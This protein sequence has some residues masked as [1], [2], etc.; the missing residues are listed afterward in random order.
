MRFKDD[1]P[2]YLQIYEYLCRQIITGKLMSNQKIP[3]IRSLA[4]LFTV[5]INTIQKALRQMNDSGLLVTKRGE[6][7][8]VTKD[9][10]FVAKIKKDLIIAEQNKFVQNMRNL[11]VSSKQIILIVANHLK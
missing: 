11:G 4:T 5:N 9:K 10:E 7:N 1:L 6:G 8:F 2:L 3:S